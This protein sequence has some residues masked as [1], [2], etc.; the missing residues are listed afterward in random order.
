M[1]AEEGL[2]AWELMSPDACVTTDGCWGPNLDPL[3]AQPGLGCG[4]WRF[5]ALK[6]A[7]AAL[8]LPCGAGVSL[9]DLCTSSISWNLSLRNN[10]TEAKTL[11]ISTS[12]LSVIVSTCG[13]LST[14]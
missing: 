1:E 13:A 4:S 5:E 2:E 12:V 7:A 9:K 6:S 14:H 10:L 8:V 3:Q 11:L